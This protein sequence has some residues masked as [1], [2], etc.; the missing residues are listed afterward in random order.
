MRPCLERAERDRRVARHRGHDAVRADPPDAG[1]R[2]DLLAQRAAG[3][4]RAEEQREALAGDVVHLPAPD[5]VDVDEEGV[6]RV[7]LLRVLTQ[8]GAHAEREALLAA[9]NTSQSRRARR[10]ALQ[11]APD[12]DQRRDAGRVGARRRARPVEIA[13]SMK[14]HHVSEQHH[15]ERELDDREHAGVGR[16]S[17]ARAPPPVPPSPSRRRC[18]AGRRATRQAAA[19]G[20]RGG[21]LWRGAPTA[22]RCAAASWLAM[23]IT[24]RDAPGRGCAEV[25]LWVSRRGI[26]NRTV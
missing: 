15:R 10:V 14:Q 1:R 18:R 22:A 20:G 21:R 13:T 4:R 5:R 23:R 25:T 9:G 2:P 17:G 16:R 3:A 26:R 19:H 24:R 12:L 8:P 11:P 6:A 7:E